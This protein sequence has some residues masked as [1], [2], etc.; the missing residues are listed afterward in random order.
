MSGSVTSGYAASSGYTVG[1]FVPPAGSMAVQVGSA[2]SKFLNSPLSF[3]TWEFVGIVF[4]A[5]IVAR[6]WGKFVNDIT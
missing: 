3:K 1:A 5:F 4:I 6:H 2:T